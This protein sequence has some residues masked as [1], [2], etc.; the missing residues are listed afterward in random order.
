MNEAGFG[1]ENLPYGVARLPGGR[2]VCVTALDGGV[3]DLAGLAEGGAFDRVPGLAPGALARPSLNRFLAG[4]RRAWSG[5]RAVVAEMADAGDE[6]VTA[7]TVPMGS[8]E[9]LLPV[10]VGDFV[11][12][13]ASRHHA[14]NMAA[15]LRPGS[16]P[17]GPEWDRFPRGYHSRA[18]AVVVS[19]TPVRR[20]WGPRAGGAGT[21]PTRAL[22]FEAEIGFVVGAPNREGRPVPATF[23]ALADHVAGVVVL[24]DWSARDVQSVESHPL[25]PLL[26]K[27][28]ATSMSPWV[29]TLDALEPWRLPGGGY[30]LELYV[31]LEAAGGGG[32]VTVSRPRFDDLHWTMAELLAHA[33]LNGSAVRTGDLFGCGTT[34]G[35][36]PGALG[37][38]AELTGAGA[39]PLVLPGGSTRAWLEDGDTVT[40]G[41]S[42]GGDGRPVVSLGAV[43]G[44]VLAALPSVRTEA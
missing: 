33:T 37:C 30:R 36:S 10:A 11:D 16:P 43:T 22:D 21:G 13:T 19:G 25:G 42:A 35:P 29:V 40:I 20:P 9:L 17:P 26:S 24:N 12:F 14:V 4:G 39:R 7:A 6:R 38:L 31:A 27:S 41:A 15:L 3:V 32:R 28:F 44:T 8:V 5:V 2:V 18:G 23:E 1:V 34:S